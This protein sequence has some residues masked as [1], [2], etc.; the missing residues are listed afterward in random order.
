MA[1]PTNIP[2][3]VCPLPFLLLKQKQMIFLTLKNDHAYKY[4]RKGM[5]SAI[6]FAETKTGEIP[7]P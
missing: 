3:R 1:T 5:H 4:L 6:P 7:D 2:E